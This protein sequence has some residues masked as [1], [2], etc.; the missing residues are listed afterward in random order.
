[1][2]TQLQEEQKD[3]ICFILSPLDSK[4]RSVERLHPNE[5]LSLSFILLRSIPPSEL[6]GLCGLARLLFL[7]SVLNMKETETHTY[8]HIQTCTHRLVLLATL[9]FS[10]KASLFQ[11]Y[12]EEMGTFEAMPLLHKRGY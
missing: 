6:M 11:F 1:M 5:Y 12:N 7:G 8:T 3:C 10:G 2:S 4:S 9:T